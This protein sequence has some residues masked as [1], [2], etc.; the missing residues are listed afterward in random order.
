MSA[1]APTMAIV[2]VLNRIFSQF[3]IMRTLTFASHGAMDDH[4]QE[5]SRVS[6]HESPRQV[7]AS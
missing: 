4:Q 2:C 3:A 5:R 6:A 1:Q 7:Q